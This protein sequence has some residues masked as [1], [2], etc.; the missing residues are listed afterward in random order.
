MAL[1]ITNRAVAQAPVE[2]VWALLSDPD[3]WPEFEVLLGAVEGPGMPLE[4]GQTLA[5]RARGPLPLRVPVEVRVVH[6]FQRLGL[7]VHTAPGVKEDID[8]LLVPLPGARTD[9]EVRVEVSGPLALPA[10]G[11][12]RASSA[13]V[14][15]SL[16][17]AAG[18]RVAAARTAA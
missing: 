16:A 17:R 11:P 5:A 6:P 15:R 3:C 8:H 2:A 9:I 10:Y 4:A 14:T 7:T 12:L 18:R 1:T 13:L